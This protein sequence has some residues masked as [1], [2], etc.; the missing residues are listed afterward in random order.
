[1]ANAT[2]SLQVS[3]Y[4]SGQ[5]S[6]I[7]PSWQLVLGTVVLVAGN[8]VANGLAITWNPMTNASGGSFYPASN[9]TTPA[10]AYFVSTTGSGYFYAWDSVHGTLRIQECAASAGPAIDITS[11]SALPSG[12]TGDTIQFLAVFTSKA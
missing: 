4:P 9:L 3:S 11:G 12:V 1:M 7:A 2:A 5:T 10:L 6:T 8:Y